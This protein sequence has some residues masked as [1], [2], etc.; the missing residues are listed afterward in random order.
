MC[1]PITLIG[2]AASFLQK[3]AQ[4]NQQNAT[5]EFNRGKALESN[6]LTQQALGAEGRQEQARA[7]QAIAAVRRDAEKARGRVTAGAAGAGVKG[8]SVD[9]VLDEFERQEGQMV[10][11]TLMNEQFA[12]AN[13]ERQ[14]KAGSIATSG[15]LAANQ[16]VMG[17]SLFAS[18]LD[19]FATSYALK[20]QIDANKKL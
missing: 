9:A 11:D 16:D 3:K 1:E 4:A 7:G 12:L 13:I 20:T 10:T 5:A 2:G 6:A 15:R 18:A 14:K 19:T 17:P 8:A